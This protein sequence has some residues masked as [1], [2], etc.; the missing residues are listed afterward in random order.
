MKQNDEMIIKYDDPD[1]RIDWPK[2]LQ[3][4]ISTKDQSG[5]SFSFIIKK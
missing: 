5:D 3:F 1:L 4:N 2:N